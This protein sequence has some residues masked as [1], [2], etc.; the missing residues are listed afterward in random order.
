[1]KF[2]LPEARVRAVKFHASHCLDALMSV[3]LAFPLRS[4]RSS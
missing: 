4:R 3:H 1:V 2:A